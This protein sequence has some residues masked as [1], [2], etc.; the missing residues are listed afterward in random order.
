ME[1]RDPTGGPPPPQ[2]EAGDWPGDA[3]AALRALAQAGLDS[4]TST[5][6]LA[7]LKADARR[8]LGKIARD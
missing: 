6:T 2:E 3:A 8:R 4:G 7:A 1:K 5:R